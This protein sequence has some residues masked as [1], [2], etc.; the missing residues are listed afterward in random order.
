GLKKELPKLIV[1]EP[2]AALYTV[3]DMRNL[4]G[5]DFDASEFALYCAQK[6]SVLLNGVKTTLLAAPMDGFYSPRPGEPNPGRTQMRIAY[7][8]PPDVMAEVPKLL[9]QLLH[10]YS[11]L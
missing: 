2:D 10:D 1:S 3:I 6:G 9:T 4:C 5:K 7:V 11:A 8:E